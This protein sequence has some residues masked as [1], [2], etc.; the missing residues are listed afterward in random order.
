MLVVAVEQV[1]MT[2]AQVQLLAELVEVVMLKHLAL[3][4]KTEPVVREAAEVVRTMD[5]QMVAQVVQV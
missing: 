2:L 4:F 1:E 5:Q 3:P